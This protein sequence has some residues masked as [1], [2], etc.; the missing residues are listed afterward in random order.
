MYRSLQA[1]ANLLRPVPQG[2]SSL[3]ETLVELVLPVLL[4]PPR[5]IVTGLRIGLIALAERA[6]QRAEYRADV[7]A[8]RV[9][10]S[11]AT[12]ELLDLLMFTDPVLMLIRRDA[13]AG[14]PPS[15][16][17]ETAAGVLAKG[18]PELEARRQRSES[19]QVGLFAT[20]P[21]LAFRAR[22]V[23]GR[24]AESAAVVL[25]EA[26]N[27]RIEAELAK[28]VARCARTLKLV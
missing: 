13:R 17:R 14:V 1:L 15:A 16:W 24:P 10:G 18:R 4:A 23:E 21:P 25:D 11:A 5:W 7:L 27:G 8:A 22:L 19:E 6:G 26:T 3:T 12:V 20:H 9:A 28:P 2:G